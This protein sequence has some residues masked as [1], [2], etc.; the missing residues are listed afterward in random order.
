MPLP[1]S[2]GEVAQLL[3]VTEPRLNDLL[4]RGHIWPAPP[5]AAGRRQWHRQHIRKAAEHLGLL[6]D[7]IL[8][9]MGEARREVPRD[10]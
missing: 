10:A 5:I 2:T 9:R 4:R 6:N 8:D 7:D 1:A 3:G